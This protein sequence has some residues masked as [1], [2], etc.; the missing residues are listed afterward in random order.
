MNNNFN[1]DSG[2]G[3]D[4]DSQNIFGGSSFSSGGYPPYASSDNSYGQNNTYGDNS[5]GQG[6]SYGQSQ[7]VDNYNQNNNYQNNQYGYNTQNNSDN[8]KNNSYTGGTDYNNSR[9]SSSYSDNRDNNNQDFLDGSYP[10]DAPVVYAE[11]KSNDK[12]NNMTFILFFAAFILMFVAT[13]ISENTAFGSLWITLT[14]VLFIC[15]FLAIFIV[16]VIYTIVSDSKKS[17]RCTQPVVARITD[18]RTTYSSKGHK[19][20]YPTY[21]YYYNGKIYIVTS[22]HNKLLVDTT[23]GKEIQLNINPQEPTE[24]SE[25]SKANRVSTGCSLLLIGY[26]VLSILVPL[27]IITVVNTVF[28]N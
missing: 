20:Y 21:K 15:I 16:P 26:I 5:Y 12:M 22:N 10:S 24:F 27:I 1:N 2:N 13:F 18:V 17:R 28:S 23:V 3:F 14:P 6:N 8:N 11:E 25:D 9:Y 19:S 4:T 7:S